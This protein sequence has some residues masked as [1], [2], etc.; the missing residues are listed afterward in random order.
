MAR[1]IDATEDCGICREQLGA[2]SDIGR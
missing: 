2:G 1:N